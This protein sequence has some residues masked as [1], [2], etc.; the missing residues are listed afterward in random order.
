MDCGAGRGAG[1]GAEAAGWVGQPQ[2]GLLSDRGAGQGARTERRQ[3]GGAGRGGLRVGWGSGR[4]APRDRLLQGAAAGQHEPAGAKKES[5]HLWAW[6]KET[7]R[8]RNQ[9]KGRGVG[10]AHGGGGGAHG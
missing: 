9:E 2:G 8:D 3:G 4:P 7:G 5:L 10:C 6:V 1:E